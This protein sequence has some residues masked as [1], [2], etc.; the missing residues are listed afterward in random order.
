MAELPVAVFEEPA[1]FR[2][3]EVVMW[4][5]GIGFAEFKTELLLRARMA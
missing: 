2:F 5:R 4:F 3:G 1:P